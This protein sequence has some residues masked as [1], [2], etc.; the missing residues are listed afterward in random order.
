MAMFAHVFFVSG[1]RISGPSNW[2]PTH[3]H[4]SHEFQAGQRELISLRFRPWCEF[5]PTFAK[6]SESAETQSVT[7]EGR[8]HGQKR[9]GFDNAKLKLE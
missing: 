4:G 2:N 1:M 8:A 9:I 3:E 6:F 5:I 7:S